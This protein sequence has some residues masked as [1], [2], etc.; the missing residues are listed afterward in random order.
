[1]RG[2]Y[3]RRTSWAIP[4][5]RPYVLAVSG[6]IESGKQAIVLLPAPAPQSNQPAHPDSSYWGKSDA[7]LTPEKHPTSRPF[8][9]FRLFSV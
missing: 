3:H 4:P 8:S 6:G 2:V 9:V 7:R 5:N 1:M